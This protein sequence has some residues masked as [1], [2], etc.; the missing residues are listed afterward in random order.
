MKFSR[1]LLIGRFQPFHK[2]HLYLL[3]ETLKIAD[4]LVIGIGSASIFDENNPLSYEERKKM[5]ETVIKKEKIG[6]RVIKIVTLEDY[7]DDQAWLA[8]VKK[9]VGDFDLVV[10]NN[11]W[12]NKI[13]EKAGY[14]IKR[15]PYYGR[16]LYEGWRIRKANFKFQISNFKFSH[17]VLGGTFDHF[18]KG[19]QSLIKTAFKYGK[20]VAIGITT[21]KLTQHK[22][23]R[24]TIESYL[25]RKK[26]LL[27]YIH[28]KYGDGR[29]K[30]APIYEFTGGADKI[31]SIEAIVVSRLTYPNALKINE[32]RK[33]NNLKLLRIIIVKDVLAED[34]KRISSER[35]RAGEIDR[36]GKCY[37]LHATGYTKHELIMPEYLREELRKPLGCV[38]KDTKDLLQCF[39][40]LKWTM[41]IAIG[42]IIVDALMKQGIEPEVKIIDF[43]SRRKEFLISNFKF[44]FKS[45][46]L[47]FKKYI[48]EP[49]T[50]NI[51]T[52]EK[53]QQMIR[54]PS[55]V[56]AK[57]WLV[58]D[59]EED[60]LALPAILFAPLGSLVLY[61]HWQL[62]VVGVEVTEEIKEKVFQTIKKFK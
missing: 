13:M 40:T 56:E 55:G 12:T 17:V 2:G 54:H 51:K 24:E 38:F 9:Q 32:L 41:V 20:K 50:I 61:G 29:V 57:S 4:K 7:F 39:K 1:A 36:N 45:K 35:I 47:N 15:F 25:V 21:E 22:R 5:I 49:G 33:K 52:A 6:D 37:T 42:D 14:K 23:L 44:L 18:H 43:R 60:L 28:K 26:N 27:A 53:L 62:G 31:K 46:F 34:G 59:G 30:I 8:N 3:K 48:N 16:K 11:D 10:G 58:I 19:H